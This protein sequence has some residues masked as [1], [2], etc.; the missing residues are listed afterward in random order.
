MWHPFWPGAP[1]GF[2]ALSFRLRQ[3]AFSS[4]ARP[5]RTDPD[6]ALS[7][8]IL[9]PPPLVCLHIRDDLAAAMP[10]S[11]HGKKLMASSAPGADKIFAHLDCPRTCRGA[12]KFSSSAGA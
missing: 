6:M 9:S 7:D 3:L 2:P 11:F 10:G 5:C 12:G 4:A 1:S 8:A